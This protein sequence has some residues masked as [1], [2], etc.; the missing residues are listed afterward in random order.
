MESVLYVKFM[1]MFLL[2]I[3]CSAVLSDHILPV[4]NVSA[5]KESDNYSR[6]CG[7]NFNK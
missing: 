2:I 6:G 1:M 4:G 3:I 7:S 5:V